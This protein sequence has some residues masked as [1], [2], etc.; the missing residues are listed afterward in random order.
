MFYWSFEF[1]H[2]NYAILD[3]C[4]IDIANSLDTLFNLKLFK[5]ILIL[6]NN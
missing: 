6:I 5:N 1:C 4:D 2:K 3:L